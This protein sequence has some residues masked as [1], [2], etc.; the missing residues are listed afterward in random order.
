MKNSRANSKPCIF[1]TNVKALFR[2]PT[3]FSFVGYNTL[4]SLGLVLLPAISFLQQISHC[5][6]ISSILRSSMKS[7]LPFHSFIQLLVWD[8]GLP[9]RKAHIRPQ[10]LSLTM[11]RDSTM[12]FLNP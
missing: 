2:A 11:K 7:R 6:S 1:M 3:P 8:L 10:Q 4:L 9:Y 5:S 12:P